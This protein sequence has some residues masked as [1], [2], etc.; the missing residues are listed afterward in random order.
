MTPKGVEDFI[1]GHINFDQ[2]KSWVVCTMRISF[3]PVLSA[4]PPFLNPF[5]LG[6]LST[7]ACVN[8][9]PWA[10]IPYAPCQISRGKK[11]EYA[12]E[13]HEAQERQTQLYV[14]LNSAIRRSPIHE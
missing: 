12:E 5:P 4:V 3:V 14:D 7:T 9:L 10:R 8:F 2:W 1:D 11:P 13:T 6:S